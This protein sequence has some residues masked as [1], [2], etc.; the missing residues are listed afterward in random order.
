MQNLVLLLS[1]KG[2]G[3]KSATNDAFTRRCNIYR[4][5]IIY[6]RGL[7]RTR[8][9]KLTA[10]FTNDVETSGRLPVLTGHLETGLAIPDD[11]G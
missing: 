6:P 7:V 1:L 10:E 5:N 8:Y 9:N 11:L 4:R 3:L 2:N